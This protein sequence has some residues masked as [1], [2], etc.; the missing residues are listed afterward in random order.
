M[1]RSAF[2]IAAFTLSVLLAH[3]GAASASFPGKNGPLVWQYGSG[4]IYKQQLRIAPFGGALRS[5]KLKVPG[6][7]LDVSPQGNALVTVNGTEALAISSL[8][9]KLIEKRASGPEGFCPFGVAFA[10]DGRNVAAVG[11]TDQ[12]GNCVGDFVYTAAPGGSPKPLIAAPSSDTTSESVDW[13]PRGDLLAIARE[14]ALEDSEAPREVVT[15][16]SKG[17]G[18]TTLPGAGYVVGPPSFSPDGGRIAIAGERG[19]STMAVDGSANTT[20]VPAGGS[21][22][23]YAA[24]SPDGQMIAAMRRSS[25]GDSIVVVDA[26]G[27]PLTTVDSIASPAR[28]MNLNWAVRDTLEPTLGSPSFKPSALRSGRKGTLRFTLSEAA[29][30]EVLLKG[31]TVLRH[32]GVPGQNSVK[33][34]PRVN[35]KVAPAGSYTL[36]V[37]SADYQGNRGKTRKL[38]VRITK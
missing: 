20:I 29:T 10:P 13:S 7:S 35:G 11:P 34:T 4:P 6:W 28:F 25:D 26:A 18:Q 5:V 38:T 32:D 22:F 3:A 17:G 37:R 12:G 30:V 31:G 14:N 9:G 36:S 23:A 27:G 8:S 2:A 19:I 33:F 21:P 1:P 24:W 15:M 16:P